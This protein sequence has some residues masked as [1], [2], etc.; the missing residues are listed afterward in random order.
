MLLQDIL[1]YGVLTPIG[2]TCIMISLYFH[3]KETR[4]RKENLYGK[5]ND[6]IHNSGGM[7]NSI[8]KEIPNEPSKE[9]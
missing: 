7:H 6:F 4:I 1:F 8:P 3:I 9:G 2:I 5:F